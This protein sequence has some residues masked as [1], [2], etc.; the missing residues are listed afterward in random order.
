MC[1][2]L[3]YAGA[4]IF[5]DELLIKPSNSLV[6]QSLSARM[7]H[8]PTQGDG[9][10]LGWYGDRATPGL[11]R[12][13]MPAW[14]DQNLRELAEQTRARLFFAHVRAS[15]G[16]PPARINCHPFRHAEWLFMHNG[17]IGGYETIRRELDMRIAPELYRHR[18]G[19]TD[20]EAIFLLAL[21]H[22]LASDPIGAMRRTLDEIEA[23]RAERGIAE[24]IRMT[25][26]ASDG[27]QLFVF[28]YSSDRKSPSLFYCTG[29]RFFDPVHGFRP[30]PGDGS[31]LVLS[32]PFDEAEDW[33]REVAENQVLIA[34]GGDV[35]LEPFVASRAAA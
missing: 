20:S 1:R 17:Q 6:R 21:G 13:V 5:L 12:D 33:W 29:E 16:A 30:T 3:A 24:P 31:V 11:Y 9:F 27:R 2:W 10:G 7:S 26:A 28:R 14:N 22:G 4:E 34:E 32:E 15:T 35:M 8:M 19:G 23:V 25:A 18:G